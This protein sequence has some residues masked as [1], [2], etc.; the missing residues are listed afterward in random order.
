LW[1][2]FL[3]EERR[4]LILECELRDATRSQAL[5]SPCG[6]LKPSTSAV[7]SGKRTPGTFRHFCFQDRRIRP[8]CHS[9]VRERI[10]YS[11]RRICGSIS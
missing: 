3:G 6:W 7:G 11:L 1:V 9:S 5:V 2:K 4:S 8:L 10:I